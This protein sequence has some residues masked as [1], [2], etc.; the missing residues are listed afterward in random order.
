LRGG[1][2]LTS[3]G[4]TDV[5]EATLGGR[6]LLGALATCLGEALLGL[7]DVSDSLDPAR[8]HRRG[9]LAGPGQPRARATHVDLGLHGTSD[10]AA[11]NGG[12]QPAAR[13]LELLEGVLLGGD[14]VLDGADR[15]LTR[16]GDVL[17]RLDDV[18]RPLLLRAHDLALSVDLLSCRVR[19]RAR[20]VLHRAFSV[21]VCVGHAFLS[22]ADGVGGG[23]LTPSGGLGVVGGGQLLL[24]L[25]LDRLEHAGQAR[26][27]SSE[28]A[29]DG[30]RLR[31]AR[32]ERGAD[33]H[34]GLGSCGGDGEQLRGQRDQHGHE[35]LRVL[36]R[37][38]EQ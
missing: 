20:E 12:L 28:D 2:Y 36:D 38:G 16:L 30:N 7:L 10:V 13:P 8:A 5:G 34:G 27:G 35:A 21:A 9:V 14:Q 19:P 15:V 17:L 25:Q 3:V 6:D 37:S 18:A 23:R 31:H 22:G 33:A 4:A 24:V 29:D 1:G 26:E 32:A 11:L